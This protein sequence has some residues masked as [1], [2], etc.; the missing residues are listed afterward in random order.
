MK[1]L[2]LIV[3]MIFMVTLAGC[4]QKPVVDGSFEFIIY[5]SDSD[6]SNLSDNKVV[7][8]YTIE[9]VDCQTVTDTLIEKDGKYYFSKDSNDYLILKDSGYGLTYTEG[10]F[11]NYAE[12]SNGAIDVSWSYTAVNGVSATVGIGETP[13]EG[14]E[15]YGFV[16]NGWK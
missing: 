8:K 12:C 5:E 11:E 6:N 4:N 14:L 9:Y 15:E 1:K 13:L 3:V 16:I 7:A 2:F 10:Y